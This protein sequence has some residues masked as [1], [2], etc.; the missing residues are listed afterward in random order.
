M[1]IGTPDYRVRKLDYAALLLATIDRFD[2]F[3]HRSDP[4]DL[5]ELLDDVSA[6]VDHLTESIGKSEDCH[7]MQQSHCRS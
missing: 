4:V 2:L 1:E 7:F 6:I 5:V 3:C